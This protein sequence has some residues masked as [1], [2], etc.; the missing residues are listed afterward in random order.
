MTMGRPIPPL[1]LSDDERETLER[2]AGRRKTAQALAFRA[3]LILTCAEGKKNGDVATAFRVTRPT[4][5]KWRARFIT[6][7]LDGLLDEPRPVPQLDLNLLSSMA[8]VAQN[9]LLE[10]CPVFISRLR[11]SPRLAERLKGADAGLGQRTR[12]ERCGYST[13]N[14]SHI[15]TL[16][17]LRQPLPISDVSAVILP[18]ANLEVSRRQRRMHGHPPHDPAATRGHHHHHRALQPHHPPHLMDELFYFAADSE[19]RIKSLTATNLR[20]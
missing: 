15:D 18:A 10:A 17:T 11:A 19:K 6:R 1:H 4:V 5:G 2:W 20:Q 16:N 12:L 8:L 13:F 9:S 14:R 3:R 7:R